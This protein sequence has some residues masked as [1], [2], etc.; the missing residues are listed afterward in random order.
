MP[1]FIEKKGVIA[2]HACTL[3]CPAEDGA[4][5]DETNL[6]NRSVIR[7]DS[8]QKIVSIGFPKFF[9]RLERPEL[10]PWN[11]EWPV[12]ATRKMDGSLLIVSKFEGELICRTRETFDARRLDNGHEIDLFIQKYPDAFNNAMLDHEGFSFLFEWTS[13]TNIICLREHEEPTLTLIGVV[14][15]EIMHLAHPTLLDGFA[16]AWGVPRPKYFEYNSI[17]EAAA[18]V[19]LWQGCEGIVYFSPDG[20]TLRKEK[21]DRYLWLHKNKEHLGKRRLILRYMEGRFATYEDFYKHIETEL[22]YELAEYCKD[23]LRAILDANALLEEECAKVRKY[24]DGVKWMTKAEIA[25]DILRRYKVKD[26]NEN[27]RSGYAFNYL[28][29]MPLEDK[30]RK[31]WIKNKLKVNDD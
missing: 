28:A 7:R 8:D 25:Q 1:S 2:G 23:T 29:G 11:P 20:Q 30:I 19:K 26:K 16:Q 9:N 6:W 4:P 22:D 14:I 17:E 15:H 21:S 27:W 12:K 13:P 31:R 10:S 18:D 5:W 24:A 3:T